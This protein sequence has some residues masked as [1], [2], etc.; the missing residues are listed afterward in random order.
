MTKLDHIG[1]KF[2]L[3]IGVATGVVGIGALLALRRPLPYTSG[4]L[5]IPDIQTQVQV[6][7]DTW[8]V[9]HVYAANNLDLFT[10]QGYIHAQDRLWQMELNRH[11]GH[12][13]LAELFGTIALPSDRF[14]RILGFSRVVKKELELLDADT[15]SLLQAY[16]QGINAFLQKNSSRLPL[17][18]TLLRH[19]PRLWNLADVLV[20]SKVLA[21]NLSENW[22]QEVLRA[23]IIAEV[24]E[25]RAR[26]LETNYPDSHPLT[27]PIGAAYSANIGD[28]TL[29]LVQKAMPFIGNTKPS[30]GSNAWVIGGNM[31]VSK[32]PLL[33]N[34]PHLD[35]NV[36]SIWYEMHL[37]G[38]DYSVTGASLPGLPGILIG[39][40]ERIAWGITNSMLDVQDLYLEQFHPDNPSLYLRCG[41]WEKVQTVSEE[42]FIK[43]QAS[44]VVESVRIT[45]HGPVVTPLISQKG[46]K[47]SKA[48][49]R[50]KYKDKINF[51]VEDLALCWTA[52]EPTP[53]INAILAVNQAGDWNEFRSAVADWR[54]P[55][56]NFVYADVDGH[57]GYALGGM[58]P[59][60][61]QGDGR[62]P[63]PGWDGAYEWTG[64][65]PTMKLPAVLDSP[66]GF[67]ATANN[68]I[69]GDESTH[70]LQGEW[71]SGYRVHRIR[72]MLESLS[73]HSVRSFMTM[74]QDLHSIPGREIATLASLLPTQTDIAIAARDVLM[75]WSGELR[76]DSVGGAI[77]STLRYHML[78]CAYAELEDLSQ[79]TVGLGG[80][81]I[82]PFDTMLSRALTEILRRIANQDD[83]WFPYEHTWNDVLEEAWEKTLNELI[84]RMGKD[85]C[86][87]TYGKIH[88]LTLNHV[89]GAIPLLGHLFNRGPWPMGGDDDTICAGY[90]PHDP[91]DNSFY[92]GSS[93]RQICD[94]GDWDCSVSIHAGGQSGHPSSGHYTRM[95]K[96]WRNGEYHPMLWSQEKVKEATKALL[97]LEPI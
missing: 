77:Y 62:I 1:C 57:Y 20:Y 53:S 6:Y 88:S 76:A 21:L 27:I 69:A 46:E 30:Q 47:Q 67:T 71:L 23:R 11:I 15:R 84:D 48:D 39:H 80:F 34:D 90:R 32:K 92:I 33:A 26:Q 65:I 52:L 82:L 10:S 28:K 73:P 17:E 4:T 96:L 31:S 64:Y 78:R 41:N 74:Q 59:I 42:I 55:P 7:R 51:P 18:F 38:G 45:C 61:A 89:L 58:I 44:P 37:E 75:Q 83:A 16:V 93:Y 94:I 9:P 36:P 66:E 60:R 14:I 87:W 97:T 86:K 3:A 49:S 43:G 22:T 2:G 19:R 12:G 54:V 50:G 40:N 35:L 72:E 8:G 85:V 56:L 81:A 29:D 68:K 79:V 63:V 24:G 13:Q 95:L 70:A 25:E 91:F 5:H